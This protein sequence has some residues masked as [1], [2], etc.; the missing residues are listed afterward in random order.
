MSSVLPLRSIGIVASD[1]PYH[2]K[3][4][5][6]GELFKGTSTASVSRDRTKEFEI[7]GVQR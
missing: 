3:L 7:Q 2:H 6:G 5:S 4:F 1:F